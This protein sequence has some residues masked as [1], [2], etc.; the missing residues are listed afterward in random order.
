MAVKSDQVFFDEPV[1]G[2]QVVVKGEAKQ[3]ADFVVAVVR[4]AVPVR[5]QDE[6]DI[7]QAF[8]LAQAAP[9]A[10]A[11]EAVLDKGEAAGD[12]SPA[13][14][15]QGLFFNHDVTS[16]PMMLRLRPRQVD[17]VLVCKIA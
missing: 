10:I 12:L 5:D 16:L 1:S 15:T 8:V 2:R 14:R 4:Q 7:E 3:R 6:K 13:I 17:R 9:E 11:Q